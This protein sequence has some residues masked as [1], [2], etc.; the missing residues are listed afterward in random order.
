MFTGLVQAVGLVEG[1][2]RTGAG[3]RLAVAAPGWTH[4]AAPGESVAVNG[5]CLTVIGAPGP[6]GRL[7]FDVVPQTLARTTLGRLRPGDPVNL[8]LA[9]RAGSLLGG[10]IV[11]GHI[12]GV[13]AVRHV[14]TDDGYR[15]SVHAPADLAPVLAPAGSVA[16]DGV[17]L[18]L[19]TVDERACAFEVALIP[20]TLRRT[21][22]GSLRPG[23]AVNLEADLLAKLVHRAVRAMLPA[24]AGSRGAGPD[25][26]GQ[27]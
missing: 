26:A 11:Q 17:S 27:S 14:R 15:V 9:L 20:E 25:A 6:G 1:A 21:T 10:H 23:D 3:L 16:L 12:D 7:E 2:H 22:L 24:L 4:R 19:A 8:E 5:C 18:T 13:G